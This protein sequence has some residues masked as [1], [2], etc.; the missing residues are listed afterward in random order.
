[1]ASKGIQYDR[2]LKNANRNFICQRIY[3]QLKSLGSIQLLLLGCQTDYIHPIMV[4][5]HK[6]NFTECFW[7]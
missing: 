5:V 7:K 4:L 1:M 6:V 2:L 3:S